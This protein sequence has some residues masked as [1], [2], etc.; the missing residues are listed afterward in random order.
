VA[1]ILGVT[2]VQVVVA[3]PSLATIRPLVPAAVAIALL[4][5]WSVQ[6]QPS[7]RMPLQ[8]SAS[9]VV[10]RVSD[11]LVVLGMDGVVIDANRRARASLLVPDERSRRWSL[12][13]RPSLDAA[14]VPALTED[15]ERTVTLTTGRVDLVRVVTVHELGHP[16]ARILSARDVTELERLRAQLADQASHD[17]LTG[18]R[19]RRHL[20]SRLAALVTDADRLDRPLAVAMVDLDNLKQLND[21]YG[22]LVGD[23]TLVEVAEVL[24]HGRA[25]DDL[26]VRSGGDEFIVA[27]P[28]R[29]AE[30]A[31]VRAEAWR[32]QAALLEPPGD[33]SI[34]ITLSVGIASWRP[35]MV[36]EGLLDAADAALYRAKAA[37]RDQVRTADEPCATDRPIGVER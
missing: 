3:T 32:V 35:P 11:A 14:L 16:V 19:N 12:Q 25:T 22:H 23:R 28:G 30:E 37:G 31:V 7:R 24:R 18:L 36:A 26:V 13:H 2:A 20:S 29:T 5:L 34:R 1:L 27:M 9:N 17:S 4:W 8:V 21:R 15:G 6:D 10:D 33:G